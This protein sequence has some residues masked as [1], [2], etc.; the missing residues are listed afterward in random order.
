MMILG[1]LIGFILG[2]GCSMAGECTGSTI[3]W[4]ATV[5]ALAGGLLARWWASIWLTGLADALE[6]QRRARAQAAEKK[7]TVKV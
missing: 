3:F 6:Q 7:T 4:H 2:A 1:A 5:A